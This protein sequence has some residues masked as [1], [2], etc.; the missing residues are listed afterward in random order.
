[1]YGL[2]LDFCLKIYFNGNVL[3]YICNIL[4]HKGFFMVKYQYL[5]LFAFGYLMAGD[6]LILNTEQRCLEANQIK[7]EFDMFFLKNSP[8][9]LFETYLNQYKEETNYEEFK[10][11]ASYCDS[12]LDY[13]EFLPN[14]NKDRGKA[15]EVII[16]TDYRQAIKQN[17]LAPHKKQSSSIT[18][19]KSKKKKSKKKSSKNNNDD[20]ILNKAIE[21]NN[22][23]RLKQEQLLARR[24]FNE[25][26]SDVMRLYQ[27]YKITLS[28]K[29]NTERVQVL[30]NFLDVI[31]DLIDKEGLTE[32]EEQLKKK[33]VIPLWEEIKKEIF[34]ICDVVQKLN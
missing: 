26:V 20:Q 30:L 12:C 19:N 11:I 17:S 7:P 25:K 21:W 34:L 4:L 1:M 8:Q 23:E 33:T 13:N 31:A 14:T 28:S 3:N 9:E 15:F 10:E 16:D 18:N 6:Q 29:V 24:S 5:W 27:G 32:T 22:R 2:F